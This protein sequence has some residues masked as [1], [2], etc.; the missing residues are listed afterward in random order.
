MG[1]FTDDFQRD[2][3]AQVTDRDMLEKAFVM[4]WFRAGHREQ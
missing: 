1:R 4:G 3:A 2:A